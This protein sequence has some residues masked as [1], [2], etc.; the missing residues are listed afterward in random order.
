MATGAEQPDGERPEPDA[1]RLQ[2]EDGFFDHFLEDD[3][4]PQDAYFLAFIQPIKR[5]V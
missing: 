3:A 4:R 1:L 5:V 2:K